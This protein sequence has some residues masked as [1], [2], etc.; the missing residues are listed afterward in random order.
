MSLTDY[1]AL[2]RSGLAVCPLALGAMTFGAGRW[3][4]DE[5]TSRS[6]FDAY[7]EADGNFLDTADVYGGGA[8]ETMLG[9]FIAARS[10]RDLATKEGFAAGQGP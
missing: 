10:L 6:I 7:V 5:A 4:S 2:V 3:G 1:R 9:S 8:S